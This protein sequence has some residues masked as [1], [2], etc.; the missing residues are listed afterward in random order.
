[1]EEIKTALII[2]ALFFFQQALARGAKGVCE[3]WEESDEFG[4]VTFASVQTV[5]SSIRL[6]SFPD[7]VGWMGMRLQ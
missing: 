3:P 1:M 5:R 7:H 6:T 4:T 2:F